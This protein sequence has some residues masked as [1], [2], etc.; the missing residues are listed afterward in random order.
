[1]LAVEEA[2]DTV[3]AA[4]YEYRVNLIDDLIRCENFAIYHCEER[5]KTGSIIAVVAAN[6]STQRL[7]V[8]AVYADEP[9]LDVKPIAPRPD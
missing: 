3:Q 1:V 9:Q 4:V 5:P 8:V 7:Q 2:L 6:G